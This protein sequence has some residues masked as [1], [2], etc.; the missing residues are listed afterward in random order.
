MK[1]PEKIKKL[2]TL[3]YTPNPLVS[4]KICKLGLAIL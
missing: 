1:L 2:K 4:F 3:T